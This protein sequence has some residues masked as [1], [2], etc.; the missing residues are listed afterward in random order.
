VLAHC[1]TARPPH[2]A[3]ACRDEIRQRVRKAPPIDQRMPAGRRP[4]VRAAVDLRVRRPP[5]TRHRQGRLFERIEGL[6]VHLRPGL[7]P[8]GLFSG[9]CC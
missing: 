5:E 7:L 2:G 4:L 9:L 1:S 6:R 8:R 3:Q